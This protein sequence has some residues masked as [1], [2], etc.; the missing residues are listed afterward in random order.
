MDE[1]D[2]SNGAMGNGP[3]G[4]ELTEEGNRILEGERRGVYRPDASGRYRLMPSE[5]WKVEEVVTGAAVAE[6]HRLADQALADCR[7]GKASPLTFHMYRCRLDPP[8]LAQT[9]GLARWR[10]R[11]HLRPGP[12]AR[13][14]RRILARYAEVLDMDP[15][16]LTREP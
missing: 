12:F 16:E 9:T 1:R 14:P 6:F 8:T 7:A 15:D 10:V 11:R 5:G 4:D 2:A 3:G 13:L